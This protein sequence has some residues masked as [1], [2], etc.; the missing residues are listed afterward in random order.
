MRVRRGFTLIELLVVISIIGVLMA[1]ILPAIGSARERARQ[2]ECTN[3][4]RQ[5]SIGLQNYLNQRNFFPNAGTFGEDPAALVPGQSGQPDPTNSIIN[6]GVFMN[7]GGNF[8]TSIQTPTPGTGL[9]D[10]GP[11]YSWVVEILPYIDAQT[12]YNEYNRSRVYLDTGQRT[13]DLAGQASNLTV[14]NTTL[15]VLTCPDDNTLLTGVGNLSY[16]CNL[17]FSRWHAIPYGWVGTNGL[18]LP[19]TGPILD[20]GH[21]IAQKTGV[22]FLGTKQGK[23]PWDYHNTTSTISDGLSSTLLLSENVLGGASNSNPYFGAVTTNWATPHPNFMGF[24]ASDNVCNNG[25]GACQADISLTAMRDPADNTK[26]VDG[27]GWIRANHTGA[28]ENINFGTQLTDEG[29]FPYAYSRH[30]GR[31]VVAMCDGSVRSVAADVNGT[32]WAKLIT[33]QG[34]NLPLQIRHLPLDT[35]SIPE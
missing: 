12:A 16:V 35:S 30:P 20:W 1:L 26:Q 25:N 24:L 32:I 23:A 2:A 28:F 17:G 10:I 29:T 14:S 11:L 33:P 8:A 6:K 34:Q 31:V 18:T 13:G 3:N 15:K 4:I 22:M 7:N 21:Q 27:P 9:D 5:L 19:Q